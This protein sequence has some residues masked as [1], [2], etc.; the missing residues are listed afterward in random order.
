MADDSDNDQDPENETKNSVVSV[1]VKDILGIKSF[2]KWGTKIVEVF[3]SATGTLYSDLTI[4]PRAKGDAKARLALSKAKTDGDVYHKLQMAKATQ[5]I[6]QNDFSSIE[7]RSTA[8]LAYQDTRQQENIEA[9]VKEAIQYANE[10][11]E[12]G[13]IPNIDGEK[14]PDEGWILEFNDLAK[15]LT[16]EEMRNL[17]GRVLANE[18]LTPG[19]F[20]LRSLITLKTITNKEALS[21]QKLCQL[22]I[23]DLGVVVHSTRLNGINT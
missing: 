14:K 13:D 3:A 15:N 11:E 21:F 20:S 16:Q 10:Q 12:V 4:V 18:T 8:R 1:D 19:T 23:Q 22:Y 7:G 5:D 6:A 17:F 2:G 9:V